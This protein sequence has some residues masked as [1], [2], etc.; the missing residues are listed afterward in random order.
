MASEAAR[1]EP[2]Q[3]SARGDDTRR[4]LIDAALQIFAAQ[5]FDGASTR[6]VADKAGANLAAIPY[7]FGSKEGLYRAVAQSIVEDINLEIAPLVARIKRALATKKIP[8]ESAAALLHEL[9]EVFSRLVIGARPSGNWSR[10]FMRE[11]LQPGAAFEI[12]YE[13]VMRGISEACARLL[14]IILRRREDDASVAIRAQTLL[15]QVLVF[16]TSGMAVLTVLGWK[17]FSSEHLRMIQTVVRENVDRIIG[18]PIRTN[19]LRPTR[20][21]RKVG[22]RHG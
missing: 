7:Y 1:H 17:D 4:R 6:T 14:A 13:G 9:M 18:A 2:V 15:G 21:L 12:L 19:R 5:G 20:K 16:R 8:R 10:F 22:A 3:T 11:Q